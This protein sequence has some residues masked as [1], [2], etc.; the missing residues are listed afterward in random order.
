MTISQIDALTK[1]IK[2][3]FGS[4][5]RFARLIGYKI[6]EGGYNDFD[7]QL[8]A[9]RY[10]MKKGIKSREDSI[11]LANIGMKVEKT[12]AIKP[13]SKE[14]SLSDLI[15]IKKAIEGKGGVLKF[16]QDNTEFK[17]SSVYELYNGGR[18]VKSKMVIALMKKLEL[19]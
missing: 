10:R 1:R 11:W 4:R 18:D 14:L 6:Q 17:Q 16:C 13:T 12:D 2:E 19:I 3:K 9:V 5:A 15:K 7:K 8:N